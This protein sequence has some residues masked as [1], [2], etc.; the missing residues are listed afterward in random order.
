VL[1]LSAD[2][3]ANPVPCE[4]TESITSFPLELPPGGGAV[5]ML[6]RAGKPPRRR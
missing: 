2:G 3:G 1:N 4:R 5:L 6:E